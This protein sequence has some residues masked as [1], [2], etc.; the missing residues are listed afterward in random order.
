MLVSYYLLI[1]YYN[2]TWRRYSYFTYANITLIPLLTPLH[3]PNPSSTP[4]QMREAERAASGGGEI[5]YMRNADDLTGKDGEIVLAEYSEQ[6]PPLMMQVGMATKFKNYFKRVRQTS[7][8]PFTKYMDLFKAQ[9]T[10]HH[11]SL[12]HNP[13]TS[14]S[15]YLFLLLH[16]FNPYFIIFLLLQKI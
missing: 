10:L 2:Y 12:A 11:S 16:P 7:P 3:C 1:L 5:F 9:R 14:L 15:H 4:P 6:Y 13:F 8:A